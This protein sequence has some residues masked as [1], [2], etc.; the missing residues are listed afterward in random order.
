MGSHRVWHNWS[1]LACVHALEKEMA[2]PSTI[3]AWRIPGT[4]EP[5]GL[6]FIGSHR[7]GHDW[8]DLACMHALE[9][10]MAT[11][12]VLAWRIP[13]TEEPGG[14]PSMGSHRVGHYWS[15]LAEAEAAAVLEK[16]MLLPRTEMLL[17]NPRIFLFVCLRC[18]TA[19]GILVPWPGIKPAPS[20]LE[21]QNLTHGTAREVPNPRILKWP[22]WFWS[23]MNSS[24]SDPGHGQFL[25]DWVNPLFWRTFPANISSHVYFPLKKIAP[26]LLWLSLWGT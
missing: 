12:P 26:E 20:A 24:C 21:A 16:F 19:C 3:L 23:L 15:D 11:T 6:L 18:C 7:V 4:E 1:D 10:E 2:T 8:D 9:K 17:V 22:R 14:L 5:G 25:N 13:G